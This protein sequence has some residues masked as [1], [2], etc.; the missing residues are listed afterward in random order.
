MGRLFELPRR[1]EGTLHRVLVDEDLAPLFRFRHNWHRFFSFLYLTG[2][3]PADMAMLT[4]RNL[5]R[6]RNVI[7]YHK[8]TGGGYEELETLPRLLDVFPV[9]MPKD[10]PLFPSLCSDIENDDHRADQL[11]E[12]LG[13]PA[14]YMESLLLAEGRPAA[15]LLAFRVTMLIGKRETNP[16]FLQAFISRLR[17]PLNETEMPQS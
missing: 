14:E 6:E 5:S 17:D 7:G 10:Q 3:K 9:N 4:G 16:L 15:S 8:Q 13:L 11:N 2:I 12:K 1:L